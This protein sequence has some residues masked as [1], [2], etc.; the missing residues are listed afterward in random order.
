MITDKPITEA[1]AR[2]V[3]VNSIYHQKAGGQPTQVDNITGGWLETDEQPYD[4]HAEVGES[5]TQ[6]ESGWITESSLAVFCNEEGKDGGTLQI[7]CGRDEA[8]PMTHLSVP[9]G[10]SCPLYPASVKY[11][12]V[13]A[14]S[15]IVHF[16]FT[17][18][19]K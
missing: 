1:R 16:R 3:V 11:W 15:G 4:R 10:K 13:K 6:L 18:F 8:D 12:M 17:L 7:Y 2:L 9:P 14:S 5:W 19:P